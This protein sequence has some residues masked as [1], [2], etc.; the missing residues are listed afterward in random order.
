MFEQ[1]NYF[2]FQRLSIIQIDQ[3]IEDRNKQNNHAAINGNCKSPIPGKNRLLLQ[4]KKLLF[5]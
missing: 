5:Q 1:T 3:E 4:K 2:F